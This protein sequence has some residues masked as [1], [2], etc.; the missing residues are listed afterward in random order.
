MMLGSGRRLIVYRPWLGG[1]LAAISTLMG[2]FMVAIAVFGSGA[3]WMGA[4]V[5]VIMLAFAPLAL[6]MGSVVIGPR[7]VRRPLPFSPWIPRHDIESI[8]IGTGPEQFDVVAF[9]ADGTTRKLV[10]FRP[11]GYESQQWVQRKRIAV[12]DDLRAWL[13]DAGGAPG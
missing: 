13:E 1:I 12:R 4:V 9:A 5:G 3:R 8:E 11:S 10:L 6:A 7:G 2:L